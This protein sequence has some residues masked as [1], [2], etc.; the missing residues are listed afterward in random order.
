MKTTLIAILLTV[1]FSAFAGEK[2]TVKPKP[3][4]IYHE[5]RE[6]MR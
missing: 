1:T 5:V 6:I 2:P 4:N 3:T